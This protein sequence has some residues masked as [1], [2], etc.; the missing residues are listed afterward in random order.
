VFEFLYTALGQALAAISPN[1]FFASLLNPVILGAFLI[2][3]AGVLVPYANIVFFFWKYWLD[4]FTYLIG[5]L[6]TQLLYDV[7][8]TCSS[9][10][11]YSFVPPSNETCKGYI[12]QYFETEIGYIVDNSSTTFCQYCEYKNVDSTLRN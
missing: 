7:D 6:L 8:I 10:Q 5:A 12:A 3:F 2:N 1:A 4:P 9:D 11:R